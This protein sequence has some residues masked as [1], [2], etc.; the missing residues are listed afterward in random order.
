MS[1]RRT[2]KYIL[3]REILTEIRKYH[4]NEISKAFV[5]QNIVSKEYLDRLI[6]IELLKNN[7]LDNPN[8]YTNNK[9][10]EILNKLLQKECTK[11]TAKY[12]HDLSQI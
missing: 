4:I 7:I 6:K 8:L 1:Y 3:E 10:I 5:L 11:C 2:D 12:I 9:R